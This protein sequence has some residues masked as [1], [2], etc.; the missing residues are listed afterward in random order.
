M[1]PLNGQ[2]PDLIIPEDG[3]GDDELA[4]VITSMQRGLLKHPVAAQAAYRALVAEGRRF[5]ATEE[6][7]QWRAR[8]EASPELSRLRS[9]WEAGTF[10]VLQADEEA[11]LP[12][13]L[14]DLIAQLASRADLE[15]RTVALTD[16]RAA[17]RSELI[18]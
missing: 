10:N 1:T 18:P 16:A 12:G 14:I 3:D 4:G 11:P 15:E 13:A 5:E 6:G 17:D 8:L 7:R 2:P 9:L